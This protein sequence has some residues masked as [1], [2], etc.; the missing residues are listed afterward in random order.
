MAERRAK[1]LEAKA[2]EAAGTEENTDNQ[3][4]TGY[5]SQNTTDTL[6]VNSQNTTED[7]HDTKEPAN[8]VDP[9]TNQVSNHQDNE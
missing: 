4:M 3:D 5:D 8:Q 7:N 9:Q 6:T 2:A 1:E